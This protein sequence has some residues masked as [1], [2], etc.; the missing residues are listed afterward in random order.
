MIIELCGLPG[1]GKSTLSKELL[2]KWRAEAAGETVYDREDVLKRNLAFRAVDRALF[3]KCSVGKRKELIEIIHKN[4]RHDSDWER[5]YIHRLLELTEGMRR[6]SNENIFLD[7]GLIQYIT[8]LAYSNPLI[9]GEELECLIER[10]FPDDTDYYIIN[11]DISVET[12]IARVK[13]RNRRNDRY[14][15]DNEKMQKKLMSVKKENIDILLNSK[16]LKR[17]KILSINMM[18]EAEKNAELVWGFIKD[19]QSAV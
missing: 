14:A 8:S 17:K 12:A 16:M 10:V 18:D 19:G 3:D 2:K 15:V 1:C 13:Q 6:K 7:E 11:C 9:P 5:R 4:A